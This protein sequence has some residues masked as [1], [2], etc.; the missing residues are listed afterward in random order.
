MRCGTCAAGV[1][2]YVLTALALELYWM[3]STTTDRRQMASIP[4]GLTSL[5]VQAVRQP[6]AEPTLTVQSHPPSPAAESKSR[7]GSRK[8]RRRPKP[9]PPPPPPSPELAL[10]P[11]MADTAWHAPSVIEASS[12]AKRLEYSAGPSSGAG[13]WKLPQPFHAPPFDA[14]MGSVVHTKPARDGAIPGPLRDIKQ[15]ELKRDW[16][17]AKRQKLLSFL[18]DEQAMRSLRYD[19]CA[20]VGSSPELLLYED[21]AAIDAHDVSCGG[22]R[23]RARG[24]GRGSGRGSGR[25][26]RR[27][28]RMRGAVGWI[29]G[30]FGVA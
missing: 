27:E 12:L 13:C 19:S 2:I 21:G 1:L 16:P 23:W 30:S 6:T 29:C 4:A 9:V 17:K 10:L 25:G 11:P 20:V 15:D 8:G 18:P 24:G 14:A 5:P 28:G 26:A 22:A 7:H 3:R